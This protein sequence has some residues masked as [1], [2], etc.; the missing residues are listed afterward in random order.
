MHTSKKKT[1]KKRTYHGNVQLTPLDEIH[2]RRHGVLVNEGLLVQVQ[3]P[4]AAREL[5]AA[6]V[7]LERAR[8]VPGLG[9]RKR[10]RDHDELDKG[11]ERLAE[12]RLLGLVVEEDVEAY[13]G[14]V[15]EGNPG[16]GYPYD[17]LCVCV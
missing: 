8:L 12:L 3:H 1:T 16:F 4:V 14:R 17:R 10:R 13:A 15:L 5:L 9:G 7:E 2:T 11:R 6:A